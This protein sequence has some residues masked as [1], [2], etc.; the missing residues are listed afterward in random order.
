MFKL[1]TKFRAYPIF[2]LFLAYGIIVGII[3]YSMGLW[4]PNYIFN[5]LGVESSNRIYGELLLPYWQATLQPVGYE[6]HNVTNPET[7]KITGQEKVPVF[8]FPIKNSSDL[9]LPV[10][11]LLWALVGLGIEFFR[12]WL[13]RDGK[14]NVKRGLVFLILLAILV[15][16][17][18]SYNMQPFVVEIVG[19]KQTYN[20]GEPISYEI[21]SMG[22]GIVCPNPN[23][24]IFKKGEM[25]PVLGI[26][27]N[28][29]TN[30]K[31]EFFNKS[32]NIEQFH[33]GPVILDAPGKYLLSASYGNKIS[34]K[35]FEVK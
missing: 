6:Y 15:T 23:S 22:F 26:A 17:G 28:A 9:Y 30:P 7:G 33:G 11:V 27:F 8:D 3:S 12:R 1:S 35:E 19:L 13:R 2:T 4:D 24:V 32:W 14:I 34:E 21:K 16:I 10:S 31:Y 5:P 25:I 20:V 29:C 18:L